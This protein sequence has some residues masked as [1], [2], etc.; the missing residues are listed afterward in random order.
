MGRRFD[1]LYAK[2]KDKFD[3]CTFVPDFD[4]GETCC[5][6]HDYHYRVHDVSRAQADR[7]L[8]RCIR[9]NGK[10]IIAGMYWVG[11][12]IFGVFFWRRHRGM[13]SD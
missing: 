5:N 2:L 9:Q 1:A 12:R 7:Q 11:V 6:R 8:F 3:G 10:P 4:F 13:K